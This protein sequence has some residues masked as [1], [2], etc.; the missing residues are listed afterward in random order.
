MSARS[1]NG[2][3]D[4]IQYCYESMTFTAVSHKGLV[5]MKSF[6]MVDSTESCR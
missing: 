3:R 5:T 1:R 6:D 2:S 4:G